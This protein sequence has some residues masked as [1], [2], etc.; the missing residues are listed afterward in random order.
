VTRLH[1][2]LVTITGINTI[3]FI[4][5]PKSLRQTSGKVILNHKSWPTCDDKMEKKYLTH[6]HNTS[7]LKLQTV[8]NPDPSQQA[9]NE[10][11]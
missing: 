4:A 5:M 2:L 9:W 6:T 8:L 7:T 1:K 3:P 11:L 10:V